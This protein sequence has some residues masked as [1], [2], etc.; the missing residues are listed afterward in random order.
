[1]DSPLYANAVNMCGVWCSTPQPHQTIVEMHAWNE[2]VTGA[3]FYESETQADVTAWTK[4]AQEECARFR[5]MLREYT[6]QR[7]RSLAALSP[8]ADRVETRGRAAFIQ[9]LVGLS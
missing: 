1:M 2:S 6:E 7:L 8:A 9:S 5:A 3:Q 4:A